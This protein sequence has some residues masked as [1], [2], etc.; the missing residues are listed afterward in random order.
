MPC[1]D[2]GAKDKQNPARSDDPERRERQSPPY[3]RA[4]K[5]S[6]E[7]G[8]QCGAGRCR[9]GSPLSG[10]KVCHLEQGFEQDVAPRREL[11]QGFHDLVEGLLV[12]GSQRFVCGILADSALVFLGVILADGGSAERQVGRTCVSSRHGCCGG[13]GLVEFRAGGEF[14]P[15]AAREQAESTAVHADN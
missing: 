13:I 8:R 10:Q 1:Q 7:K 14:A 15:P 11:A 5:K 3:G 12:P 4:Q 9:G 2:D 6:E